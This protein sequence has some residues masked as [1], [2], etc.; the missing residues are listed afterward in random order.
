MADLVCL[1]LEMGAGGEARVYSMASDK[2]A[3]I[4]R[5]D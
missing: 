3:N 2:G 1:L 4:Q 5:L